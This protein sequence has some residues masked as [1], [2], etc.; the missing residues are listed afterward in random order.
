ME[1]EMSLNVNL[2][3]TVIK[4]LRE[5]RRMSQEGLAEQTGLSSRQIQRIEEANNTMETKLKNAEKIAAVLCV[6]LD[7]LLQTPDSERIGW[8]VIQ[9]G[10][11]TGVR[12]EIAS[13]LTEIKHSAMPFDSQPR[14]STTLH[15]QSKDL[16][17]AVTIEH[18]FQ[19]GNEMTWEFRP[20]HYDESMGLL[21]D[22]TDAIDD[23][24]WAIDVEQLIY[25]TAYDVTIN[26][27]P[28]VPDGVE[29][30]YRVEFFHYAE[31]EQRICE[32]YQLIADDSDL[33]ISLGEWLSQRKAKVNASL[34]STL[35]GALK[36][37]SELM[38]NVSLVISRIWQDC[39]GE[40][41]L[42]PWTYKHRESLATSINKRHAGKQG[43][44]HVTY[45][46]PMSYNRTVT[47]M[48]PAQIFA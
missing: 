36:I 46:N 5:K 48:T 45:S 26:A 10:R 39:N 43:P 28:I 47:P 7:S 9:D 29:P 23:M 31:G 11:V 21:W 2:S 27:K 34:S 24:F 1:F 13:L 22:E 18:H 19:G 3:P 33:A 12:H 41:H 4:G 6:P 14:E 30:Q 37:D 35:L 20:V 40:L 42:A 17:W 44:V 32:G 25:E 16:P 8:L 38:D 15:V